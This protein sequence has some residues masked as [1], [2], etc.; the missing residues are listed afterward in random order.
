MSFAED[1][2]RG[3]G[4]DIGH[5]IHAC[6]CASLV[7]VCGRGTQVTGEELG[8]LS[9]DDVFKQFLGSAVKGSGVDGKLGALLRSDVLTRPYDPP[10]LRW[11]SCG[12]S[13]ARKLSH[14]HWVSGFRVATGRQEYEGWLYYETY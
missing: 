10:S 12:P 1:G 3:R 11:K 8:V 4:G 7:E 13:D 5:C 14:V 9:I 6:G 2:F